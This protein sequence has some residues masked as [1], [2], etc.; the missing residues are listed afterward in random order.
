MA[1]NK[2]IIVGNWKMNPVSLKEAEKI[3]SGIAKGFAVL[4]KTQVI[5]CPPALFLEKLK[6]VSTKISLGSQDAFW[7]ESGAFTGEISASMLDTL[8]VRYTI[9][10][11]S[12]QR[13]KYTDEE[14]NRKVRGCLA[15][16]IIPILCVGE[17]ERD[18][19]HK[20]LNF[21]KQQVESALDKVSKNSLAKVIIAYEPIWA[22][23]KTA[24]R[25][26]TSAE[27][28]EMSLLIKKV[29]NDKFGKSATDTVKILYGGSV[30]TKNALD[31]LENGKADGLLVGR[32]S[33]NPA[34][35]TEIIK[36]S[37]NLNSL[38]GPN[39]K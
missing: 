5:I 24:V 2:K 39:K 34:K 22:I 6:K 23:G 13:H 18:A 21:V 9:V 38:K 29:L 33:L 14:I 11:H 25:E 30:N 4:K 3:F 12:E 36:T 37:E 15:S 28:L 31:F 27:F 17:T 7:E 8:G 35:F 1:I 10:G 26:A 16:G 19:D 32:E 20:Y